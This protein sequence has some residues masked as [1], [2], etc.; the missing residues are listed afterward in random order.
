MENN[1][2]KTVGEHLQEKINESI[3]VIEE[4]YNELPAIGSR[5]QD[6]IGSIKCTL[7]DLLLGHKVEVDNSRDNKISRNLLSYRIAEIE[8]IY[9]ELNGILTDVILSSVQIDST[10]AKITDAQDAA[11]GWINTSIEPTTK[12][13]EG[14]VVRNSIDYKSVIRFEKKTI[15]GHRHVIHN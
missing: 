13:V 11:E 14:M 9:S 12:F 6:L 4:R 10:K 15:N 5:L 8:T 7:N 3:R 2:S 1:T